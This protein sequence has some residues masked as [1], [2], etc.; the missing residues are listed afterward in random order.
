MALFTMRLKDV[1]R[2][3]DNIGLNTYPIFDEDYREGLNQK[4]IDR[5]FNREIGM[6]TIDMFQ[7]AM[8]R[9]MNEIMPLY[10]KLYLSEQIKF[11]PL[12]TVDYETVT[13]G[14]AAESGTSASTSLDTATEAESGT[15]TSTTANTATANEVGTNTSTTDDTATGETHSDNTTNSNTRSRAVTSDTPQT[16]LSGDEDY[17]SGASDSA[18][19]TTG[20][21]GQDETTEATSNSTS[22][23][24]DARD[25]ESTSDSTTT[26]ET[27]RESDSQSSVVSSGEDARESETAGD[28]RTKGR[29]GML[30]SEAMMKYRESLLNIDV[31]IIDELN[32][33]FMKIWSSGDEYHSH[34]YPF[35]KWGMA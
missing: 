32:G 11:D 2:H 29:Q 15:N 14:T 19:E 20:T 24:Q 31:D 16:M 12:H 10:N 7:L 22:S 34:A 8:R 26:G 4:I 3:T 18:S 17:A 9:K 28:S 33:L 27:G 5:Y 6:E 30:G 21:G 35:G 13:T 25:S 1:M 23:G